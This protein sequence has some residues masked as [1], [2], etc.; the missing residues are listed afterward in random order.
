MCMP[1]FPYRKVNRFG[2]YYLK[3]SEKALGE[4]QNTDFLTSCHRGLA[5]NLLCDHK[6]SVDLSTSRGEV[7]GLVPTKQHETGQSD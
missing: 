2:F 5:L 7:S 3:I 1:Q 6:P 4:V